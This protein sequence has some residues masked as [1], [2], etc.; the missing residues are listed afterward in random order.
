MVGSDREL[1]G[2]SNNRHATRENERRTR[3][4]ADPRDVFRPA[5]VDVER[6]LWVFVT[7]LNAAHRREV[8]DRV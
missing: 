8:H 6:L 1:N 3:L 4:A 5:D 2:I 7:V